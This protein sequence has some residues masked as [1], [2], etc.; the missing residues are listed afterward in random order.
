MKGPSWSSSCLVPVLVPSLLY[1]PPALVPWT[2]HS[3][4]R[5][6]L[7]EFP[8]PE[9]IHYSNHHLLLVSS[10]ENLVRKL[11]SATYATTGM[12]VGIVSGSRF[13]YSRRAIQETCFSTFDVGRDG[14]KASN[15]ISRSSTRSFVKGAIL[16]RQYKV[17]PGYYWDSLES[18]TVPPRP[19][20]ASIVVKAGDW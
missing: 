5:A 2:T 11:W 12:Q 7:L 10:P 19:P 8:L 13:Q 16:P 9:I 17:S 4:L 18:T 14:E 15:I 6:W 20:P 3:D 1:L